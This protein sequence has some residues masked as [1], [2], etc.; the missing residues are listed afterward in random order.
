[1]S[2]GPLDSDAVESYREAGDILV[3][4]MSDAN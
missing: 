2:I 4:T 1:M 3:E